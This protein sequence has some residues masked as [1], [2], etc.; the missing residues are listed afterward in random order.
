MPAPRCY[1]EVEVLN[2]K[3]F[4]VGGVLTSVTD[5]TATSYSFDIVGNEWAQMANAPYAARGAGLAVYN[6]QIYMSGGYDGEYLNNF[7]RLS[8]G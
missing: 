7:Y 1:K 2:G 4:V 6:G 3:L 5:Y 8:L